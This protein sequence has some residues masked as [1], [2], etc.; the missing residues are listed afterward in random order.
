MARA[1]KREGPYDALRGHGGLARKREQFAAVFDATAASLDAGSP[2][3]ETIIRCY[4]MVSDLLEE[5][6][7]VNGKVL[8]PREFEAR[9]SQQLR[10]DSVYLGQLT[11]LFE[12]ARYSEQE[13]TKA[14]SQE[15]V[16]CLSNL[17]SLLKQPEP[18]VEVP[19]ARSG[20]P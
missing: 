1:E 5:R 7:G 8:T 4:K 18:Q 11:R 14:Q 2:Y 19:G 6:S 9:I 10:L 17:S 13:I 15:A 20:A 12:V 3:R 16:T